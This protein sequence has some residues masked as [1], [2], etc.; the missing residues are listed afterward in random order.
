MSDPDIVG[1][2]FSSH[3]IEEAALRTLRDWLPIYRTAIYNRY[4]VKLPKIESWGLENS[5][6][7]RRPEQKLPTLIVVAGG[8]GQDGSPEEHSGGMYRA[9]WAFGVAVV[10]ES[11]NPF[12]ARRNAQLYGAAVRGAILQH[13]SLGL[14]G[15]VAKWLDEDFP[16]G[17]KEGRTRAK[18]ESL[19][20]L[21]VDEV[22]NWQMGPKGTPPNSIPTQD[23]K[24]TEVDVDV[25][26]E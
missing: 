12:V 19:F 5:T 13:R 3:L 1:P 22:V 7:D 15:C 11:G 6:A 26:V 14:D 10:V 20:A 23:P 24:I 2:L 4:K 9:S 16:Y 21:E 8:I 25:E 18:A 17:S